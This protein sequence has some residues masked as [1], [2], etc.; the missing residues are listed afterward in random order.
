MQ[1]D[2][3]YLREATIWARWVQW[4]QWVLMEWWAQW[5]QWAIQAWATCQVATKWTSILSQASAVLKPVK[6]SSLSPGDIL[7]W[8]LE[9]SLLPLRI[10]LI[11][12]RKDF[13]LDICVTTC[14]HPLIR[15]L[16][17]QWTRLCLS[18]WTKFRL[19]PLRLGNITKIV[20][21]LAP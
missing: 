5:T 10:L 19:A 17:T 12:S 15:C 4:A 13:R 6:R 2:A 7:L 14:S 11:Y 21:I 18:Q 8:S 20:A 9:S 3:I 16:A 1:T